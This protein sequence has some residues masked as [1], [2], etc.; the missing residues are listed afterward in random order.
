VQLLGVLVGLAVFPLA[1]FLMK[2]Q[3]PLNGQMTIVSVAVIQCVAAGA[4]IG[5]WWAPAVVVA[6]PWVYFYVITNPP[7]DPESLKG[8]FVGIGSIAL[9]I[10]VWLG[11]GLRKAIRPK[12]QPRN[13][14]GRL[15]SPNDV[16]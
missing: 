7:D 3:P 5:K 15:G 4:L 2:L 1:L 10:L 8:L 14:S 6:Q 13:G 16:P 12:R 9:A 11:V